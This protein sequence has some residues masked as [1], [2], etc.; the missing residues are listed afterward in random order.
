MLAKN[1]LPDQVDVAYGPQAIISRFILQGDREVRE[2]GVYLSVEHDFEALIAFN[3]SQLEKWFPLIPI[4]DP[5][6]SDLGPGNAFWIAGRNRDG[7]IVAVQCARRYDWRESDF[8]REFESLRFAYRDPDLERW[9]EECTFCNAPSGRR[10]SGMV[11]YSGGA[12]YHP[13]HRGTGLASIIPRLSRTIAYSRWNTDFTVSVVEPVLVDKGVVA[14]YGYTRIEEGI[15]WLNSF[16]GHM[17][18]LSL[19]SM[20]RT[21][22]LNDLVTQLSEPMEYPHQMSAQM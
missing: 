14:R 4:F 11:C 12:W 18:N 8:K 1:R 7:E 16:R 20:D 2:R 5:A 19:L 21:E 3:K 13:D 6:C 9:P 10:I 15:D 22:L 17:F